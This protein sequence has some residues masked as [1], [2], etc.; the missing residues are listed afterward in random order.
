VNRYRKTCGTCGAE[1]DAA[2]FKPNHNRGD[3]LTKNCR[4]CLAGR[5]NS[6]RWR[7]G[8]IRTD[9]QIWE[10]EKARR[11]QQDAADAARDEEIRKLLQEA[12]EEATQ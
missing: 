3:G 1:K 6:G 10:Q 2:G 7:Q 12:R 11:A 4:D 5:R 8:V 9:K